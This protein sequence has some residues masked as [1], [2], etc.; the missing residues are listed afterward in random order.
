VEGDDPCRACA[1]D[2]A[3]RGGS[4]KIDTASSSNHD[5]KTI[6]V[7]RFLNNLPN[8]IK[9]QQDQEDHRLVDRD[10]HSTTSI[11]EQVETNSIRVESLRTRKSTSYPHN[12][13]IVVEII[14]IA[15]IIE[16][17]SSGITSV[18]VHIVQFFLSLS[19]YYIS[20]SYYMSSASSHQLRRVSGFFGAVFLTV[21]ERRGC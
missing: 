15:T 17:N 16:M 3:R 20:L 19:S 6:S 2:G 9:I 7:F 13:N 10:Q 14:N 4:A 21:S 8:V 11:R 1:V 18:V 12:N 5:N